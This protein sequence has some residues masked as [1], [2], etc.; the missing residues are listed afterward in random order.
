MYVGAIEERKNIINLIH[1]YKKNSPKERLVLV[2]NGKIYLNQVKQEIEK[3]SLEKRV[4]LLDSVLYEDLPSLYQSAK[5]FCF[6]SLFEGFGI[7]IIEALFSKVPVI[8]SKGSCFPESGGP[9]SIYVDPL[10][11]NSL[12]EGMDKVLTD[13]SLAEKMKENGFQFV[14]KF[15]CKNTS[16]EMIKIYQGDI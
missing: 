9:D 10:D 12:A 3:L 8:T 14:Q 11:I 15:H 1:A 16:S 7:P 2:G 5:L 13:H 6:P 4:D